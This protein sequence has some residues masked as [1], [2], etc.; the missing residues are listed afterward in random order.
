MVLERQKDREDDMD[1]GSYGKKNGNHNEELE[2][3]NQELQP[4]EKPTDSNSPCCDAVMTAEVI[5][6]EQEGVDCQN[7]ENDHD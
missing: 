1:L 5:Q 2:E 7:N 6:N 4:F 3:Q